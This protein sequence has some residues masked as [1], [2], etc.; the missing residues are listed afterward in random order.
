MNTG[1]L[2]IE[3]HLSDGKPARIKA[4]DIQIIREPIENGVDLTAQVKTAIML[5]CGVWMHLIES[6]DNVRYQ[7]ENF[8]ESGPRKN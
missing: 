2:Y 7:V 3:F 4:M 8:I 5:S 6:P 1:A